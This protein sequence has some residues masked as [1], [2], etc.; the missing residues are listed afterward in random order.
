MRAISAELAKRG[1]LTAT[2]KPFAATAVK[3]M[4]AT[5]G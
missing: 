2:G 4:L 5:S 1:H 3:L